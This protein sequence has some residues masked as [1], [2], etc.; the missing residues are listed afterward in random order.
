MLTI[1]N[2]LSKMMCFYVCKCTHIPSF[3]IFSSPLTFLCIL[4]I[5]Q[6]LYAC[7]IKENL[8]QM[9]LILKY[10]VTAA[11][12]CACS[13]I[14]VRASRRFQAT[15]ARSFPPNLDFPIPSH[16]SPFRVLSL[17]SYLPLLPLLRRVP[18]CILRCHVVQ[19]GSSL[20]Y[21]ERARKKQNK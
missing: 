6:P 8:A 2:V 13:I 14:D 17:V 21:R 19:C 10:T 15:S 1:A 9:G 11:S 12:V 18:F 5:H 3:S 20:D 16:H 7:M 4:N